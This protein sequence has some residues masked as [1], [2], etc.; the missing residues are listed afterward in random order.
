MQCPRS[1]QGTKDADN[2]WYHLLKAKLQDLGM[3]TSTYVYGGFVW[4][5]KQNTCISILET[6]DLLMAS[7]TDD[8]FHHLTTE[9]HKLFDLTC[10]QGSAL[11]F[12]N[13]FD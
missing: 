13:L 10:I 2:H 1:I 11:K 7:N 8:P 12:L 9:L 4:Y 5:W 6:N 3:T